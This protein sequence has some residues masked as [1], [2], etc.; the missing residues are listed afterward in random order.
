MA[1]VMKVL[2]MVK[3]KDKDDQFW[4]RPSDLCVLFKRATLSF[5]CL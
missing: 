3:E 2:V 4:N 1:E 5:F